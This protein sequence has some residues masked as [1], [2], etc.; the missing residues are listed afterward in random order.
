M[1]DSAHPRPCTRNVNLSAKGG[2]LVCLADLVDNYVNE[3]ASLPQNPAM[4][5]LASCLHLSEERPHEGEET[6]DNH[7]LKSSNIRSLDE[8]VAG[9]L[10]QAVIVVEL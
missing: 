3:V 10:S 5:A 2:A 6:N 8:L 1:Y 9:H 4:W 7:K